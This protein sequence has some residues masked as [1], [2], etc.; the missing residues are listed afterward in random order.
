MPQ[1]WKD[2]L[3]QTHHEGWNFPNLIKYLVTIESIEKRIEKRTEKRIEQIRNG[4]KKRKQRADMNLDSDVDVDNVD[5]PKTK[6]LNNKKQKTCVVH[7]FGH[8]HSTDECRVL[9]AA[10]QDGRLG[11]AQRPDINKSR[12]DNAHAFTMNKSERKRAGKKH[13]SKKRK[14]R[15]SN[16]DS[17][18]ADPYGLGYLSINHADTSNS[19]SE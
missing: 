1:K 8:N 17:E 13:G 11:Q 9:K 18:S 12:H 5:A 16:S 6:I 4:T 19:D 15:N 2:R 7:P 14:K 10:I 3:A